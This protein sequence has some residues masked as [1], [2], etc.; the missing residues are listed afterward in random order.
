MKFGE[1]NTKQWPLCH[2]RSRHLVP[3]KR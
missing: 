3:I 2:S 1:N